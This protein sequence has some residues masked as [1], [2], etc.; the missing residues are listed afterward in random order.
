MIKRVSRA[1]IIAA[2]VQLS[3]AQAG[4]SQSLR[5]L[6]S[7]LYNFGSC[8]DPLCLNLVN[9]HGRHFGPSQVGENGAMLFFFEDGLANVLGTLPVPAMSG[10]V[11]GY[12]D[13]N[14]DVA[15][16]S[17][18]PIFAERAETLGS[19]R[20]F[21]GIQTSALSASN[22][23]GAPTDNLLFNFAHKN[24]HPLSAVDD[25]QFAGRRLDERDIFQVK[26]AL[27]MDV[28]V[29]TTVLSVGLT[30]FMDI[31]VM[32]PVVRTRLKGR[33]DGHILP[34]DPTY[35]HRFGGTSTDPVMHASSLVNGTATGIGD[36]SA[37]LKINLTGGTPRDR[38][39]STV[40][41]AI[42]ADVRLP[43]GDADEF[44][45]LE[46]GMVRALAIVSGRWGGISPHLN[47]GYLLR[48]EGARSDAF[49]G[50]IGLD[51]RA[52]D[53]M[54]FAVDLISQWEHDGPKY[55]RPGAIDLPRERQVTFHDPQIMI[56]S[57]SIPGLGSPKGRRA[58]DMAVGLKFRVGSDLLLVTNALVP[59]RDVG[60]R[61]EMMWTLA[62]QSVFR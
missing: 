27:D 6:V 43:T 14:G 46:A 32:I 17:F 33:S 60:L 2:T 37:R 48:Q 62:I 39:P 29:A 41:V 57:S 11:I 9:G 31:G 61:P 59:I 52:S 36:V 15:H 10:D 38:P 25:P 28:I 55:P 19:K 13:E 53:H 50:T 12:V 49:L 21:I 16:T 26:T 51:A 5:E 18:G 22:F 7:D 23:N 56:E 24:S 1:L 45:G 44:L 30:N 8:G 4:S 54:T 34:L 3:V 47:A 42:L 35:Q 40:G 58:L 20:F